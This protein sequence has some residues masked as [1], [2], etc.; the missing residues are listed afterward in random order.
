MKKQKKKFGFIKKAITYFSFLIV[1]FAAAV[2]GTKYYLY[3]SDARV[4]QTDL[5]Q[6]SIDGIKLYD[7]ASDID[8]SKYNYTEQVTDKCN[9]NFRELSYKTNSKE[10]VDYIN[11]DFKKVDVVL[12]EEFTDKPT[13][14]KQVWDILGTNYTLDKY[15]PEENNYW[16]I[17]R[18]TDSVH[19]IYVGIVYSRYNDEIYRIIVSN[20]KIK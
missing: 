7:L 14:V 1:I 11:A 4:E 18:Y 17:C 19:G 16:K 13:R 12:S 5:S 3:D 10:E 20:S 8:I 9:Y 6:V 2:F 15:R